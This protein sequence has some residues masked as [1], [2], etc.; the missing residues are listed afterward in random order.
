MHPAGV[1]R[2]H[3]GRL[4]RRL[5][6]GPVPA[7]RPQPAAASATRPGPAAAAAGAA[8]DGVPASGPAGAA[9]ACRC[10]A[11]G[12]A[13]RQSAAVPPAAARPGGS[14]SERRR[15]CRQRQRP[16]QPR[17]TVGQRP[18]VPRPARRRAGRG[19]AG[20]VARPVVGGPGDPRVPESRRFCGHCGQPVGQSRD[21]R[22]GMTEGFCPNCGTRFS[23][24]PKLRAGG[25]GGRPVRGARLPRP[26]RPRLDLPGP[27]PQRERP[28]GGAQGPAQHRRRG[29]DG[30]RR[31]RGAV[32]G[33]AR[34]PE[35]RPDL[36][37]R[38]A[39]QPA[40]ARPRAT[41]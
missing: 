1:Q 19:A 7:G 6:P 5:R 38:P 29:R 9:R 8:R 35:H 33:P 17:L 21:G 28:L 23:F 30:G 11:A 3:P 27:G 2:N 14:G 37:L 13:A 4:L 16:G 36:Q 41:S 24:S 25:A 15:Q 31:G 40:T 22:P 32:P 34:A 26:R 10:P 20:P 18:G 39:R 12:A